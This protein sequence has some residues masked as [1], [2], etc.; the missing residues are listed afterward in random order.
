[1]IRVY[2]EQKES[3]EC[4]I[5]V[6]GVSR[7]IESDSD[8]ESA[9]DSVI[10][11]D[12]GVSQLSGIFFCVIRVIDSESECDSTPESLLIRLRSHKNKGYSG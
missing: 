3:R 11:R 8:S 2:S 7:V 4:V 6:T 1:V 5:R 10:P 9:Q 12:S